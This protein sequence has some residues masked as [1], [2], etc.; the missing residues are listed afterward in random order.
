MPS[1]RNTSRTGRKRINAGQTLI[2]LALIAAALWLASGWR[3]LWVGYG[4]LDLRIASGEARFAWN[5]PTIKSFTWETVRA[6]PLFGP[7]FRTWYGW[8]EEL[9][10]PQSRQ[11]YG[12]FYVRFTSGVAWGTVVLLWPVPLILTT[13]GIPLLRS[14]ITARNRAAG[15]CCAKCGYSRDGLG[16]GA[17]C[18]ECGQST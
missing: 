15:N 12:V 5:R 11:V 14:G 8:G 18:P 2:A 16:H 17:N 1:R 7:R 4:S 10:L 6:S 9:M 3:E 13:V